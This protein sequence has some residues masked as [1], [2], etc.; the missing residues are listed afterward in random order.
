M[1]TLTCVGVQ[2]MDDDEFV[3]CV[4]GFMLAVLAASA[5]QG[6]AH[7]QP[8]RLARSESEVIHSFLSA[9]PLPSAAV[10]ELGSLGAA[11]YPMIHPISS[12][13]TGATNQGH[14]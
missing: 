10:G 3:S 7:E 12:D 8:P 1:P 9:P 13:A 5:E 11:V 4:S 14:Q 6:A 2:P